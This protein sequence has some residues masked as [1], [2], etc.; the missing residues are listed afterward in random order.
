MSFFKHNFPYMSRELVNGHQVFREQASIVRGLRNQHRATEEAIAAHSSELLEAMG[1]INQSSLIPDDVWRDIDAT[2]KTVMRD[3]EGS[4]FVNDLMPLA[5]TVNLGKTVHL[6]R[7]SNDAGIVKRSIS[8][9]VPDEMDKVNYSFRG[10][11]VPMFSTSYGRDWREWL[12][13]RSEGFDA[14]IDDA[15]THGAELR[16]NIAQYMLDGD[17][18][19]V[20]QGYQG[21]GIKNHPMTKQIDLSGGGLNIDLT[22][23]STTSDDIE[24]FFTRDVGAVM[25]TNLITAPMNVYVSPEIMRRFE[26]SYSAA[27]GFKG[28]SLYDFLLRMGRI[29]AIK[30]TYELSGNEFFMLVPNRKFIRPLIGMAAATVAIPRTQMTDSYQF[31]LLAAAGLEIRADQPGKSGVFYATG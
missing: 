2:T 3:D 25:D 5:R 26:K 18:S 16:Q 31:R 10:H 29:G 12:G 19:I 11:P 27:G 4:V 13:Q 8:G 28:G 23:N 30:R 6:Y 9:N 21:Y 7:V 17:S 1:L 14:L 20:V 22:S 15:E 24:T